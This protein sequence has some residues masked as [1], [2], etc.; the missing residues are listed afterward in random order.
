MASKWH[1]PHKT[2][3][4]QNICPYVSMVMYG[5]TLH[6]SELHFKLMSLMYMIQMAVMPSMKAL[7]PFSFMAFTWPNS[8]SLFN[9]KILS[10]T[11]T[12][13]A[14]RSLHRHMPDELLWYTVHSIQ[15]GHIRM[16]D[17]TANIFFKD[18][19]SY[20]NL[21]SVG[22]LGSDICAGILQTITFSA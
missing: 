5:T 9:S 18:C 1:L 20:G 10:S 14:P 7:L 12:P 21:A 3:E 16:P 15:T 22:D 17:K 19:T 11:L 8:T 6:L 2:H 13:S 4:R